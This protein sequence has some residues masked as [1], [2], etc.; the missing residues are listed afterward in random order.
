MLKY[1][2]QSFLAWWKLDLFILIMYTLK[3]KYSQIA[4]IPYGWKTADRQDIE[5]YPARILFDTDKD[6]TGRN[7]TRWR[8]IS[9]SHRWP[10]AEAL[11]YKSAF[12]SRLNHKTRLV[13]ETGK[14]RLLIGQLSQMTDRQ[15]EFS[16]SRSQMTLFQVSI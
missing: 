11:R 8:T 6:I 2:F 5:E 10:S 4:K 7:R 9:T 1:F 16:T 12:T 13:T 3:N 15:S 14:F